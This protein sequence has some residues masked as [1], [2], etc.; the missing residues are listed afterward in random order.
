M[1]ELDELM[2]LILDTPDVVH[3]LRAQMEANAKAAAGNDW[4]DTERVESGDRVSCTVDPRKAPCNLGAMDA[5]D[6]EY[7]TLAN[8]ARA[9]GVPFFGRSMVRHGRIVGM[10]GGDSLNTLASIVR[11][12]EAL[13]REGWCGETRMLADMRAVRNANRKQWGELDLLLMTGGK[14]TESFSVPGLF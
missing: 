7:A 11:A 4:S 13:A 12:F 5:A 8:W 14:E 10:A 9:V 3:F 1:N 6:L 2:G